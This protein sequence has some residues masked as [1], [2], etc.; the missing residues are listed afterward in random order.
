MIFLSFF[1]NVSLSYIKFEYRHFCPRRCQSI[2]HRSVNH[3]NFVK[4]DL[5]DEALD[6]TWIKEQQ[7]KRRTETDGAVK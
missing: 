5:L 2:I 3:I 4:L 7:S 6:E 1:R